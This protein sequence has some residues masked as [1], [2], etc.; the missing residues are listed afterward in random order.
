MATV[1]PTRLLILTDTAILGPGG[2]ER[3]LRNLLLR[4]VDAGDYAVDVLQLAAPPPPRACVAQL[5][6]RAIRLLYR[7]IEAIYAPAGLAAFACVARRVLLGCYDILQSQH[8]KSDLINALLPRQARVR[9]VSNRRDMG[10]QKS[11]RVRAVLRRANA[12]FDRIVA[13]TS[14]ILDALVAEENV[15]RERCRTIPNG[16]DTQR[17]RAA[18]AARRQQL[19]NALG[20]SGDDC[21]IGCVASF[22]PVKQHA[23]LI[24]AFARLLHVQ[25][26]ARLLLVGDGPLRGVLQAQ[27]GALGIGA[28][29][30]LLGARADVEHILPALDVFVLASSSEGMSNAILEAQAC[31]LPVVATAVGGNPDLV[32]PQV[33]GLLVPPRAAH[34]LAAALNVLAAQA[35]RRAAMGDAARRLVLKRYSLDAMTSGYVDL[36]RELGHA[37]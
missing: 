19:R 26:H 32:K 3:F 34:D 6:H 25:P 35:P 15:L 1:M 7:P 14:A 16:V 9:R 30:Q 10:F 13:P 33:N 22:T 2:S 5:E 37:R 36:Y 4:L 28:R 27:I 12:R 24:E 20:C 23:L 21:V 31:A 11:S 18:G 29:V 17:F 8:E